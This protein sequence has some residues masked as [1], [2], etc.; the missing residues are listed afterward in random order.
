ME[1]PVQIG[2]VGRD[3]DADGDGLPAFVEYAFGTS[4]SDPMSGPGVVTAGFD[5]EGRFTVTFPRNL[6]ADDAV[7][8]VEYS[9]DLSAWFP[10]VLLSTRTTGGGTAIET[11]GAPTLGQSQLFLRVVIQRH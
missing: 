8:T 3:V 10:T 2:V 6:R 4:D 1:A 5:T 9:A 7:I 11:W